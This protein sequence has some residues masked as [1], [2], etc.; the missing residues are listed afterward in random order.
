MSDSQAALLENLRDLHLP[1]P[2]NWWPLA[3]GWWVLGAC[4]IFVLLFA[5]WRAWRQHQQNKPYAHALKTLNIGFADWQQSRDSHAYTEQAACVLRQLAIHSAGRQQV[6]RLHG[7]HWVDW[8]ELT[9]ANTLSTESR[10]A[11]ADGAYQR[12]SSTHVPS[13]HAD[14]VRWTRAFAKTADA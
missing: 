14:L 4:T 13:L 2:I 8:L 10:F 7:K 1:P 11:L 6:S 3:P 5:S 9:A 12:E